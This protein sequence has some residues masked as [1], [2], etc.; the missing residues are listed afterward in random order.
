MPPGEKD[1]LRSLKIFLQTAVPLYTIRFKDLPWEDLKQIMRE[2]EKVLQESG[3]LAV[4][5]TIKKDATAK[6]FNAIAKAIAA[7]S[8]VPQGIDIFGLHFETKYEG[9][10][11]GKVLKRIAPPLA[12]PPA[13]ELTLEEFVG[14]PKMVD[15]SL[16]AWNEEAF[17]LHRAPYL[18]DYRIVSQF[19]C[20]EPRLTYFIDSPRLTF[21]CYSVAVL[22]KNPTYAILLSDMIDESTRE[23]LLEQ[24]LVGE[25]YPDAFGNVLGILEAHRG[26]GVG[27]E[28][29]AAAIEATGNVSPPPA[30]SPAGLKTRKKAH[31]IIVRNALLRGDQ[32]PEKVLDEYPDLQKTYRDYRLNHAMGAAADPGQEP[33]A[34]EFEHAVRRAFMGVYGPPS[35]PA[36]IQ[37]D[38][39]SSYLPE[40]RKLGWTEPHP[41][42]VLVI[43]ESGWVQDPYGPGTEHREWDRAMKVLHSLGWPQAWWDSI[44]PA[45]HVVMTGAV[46]GP[47]ERAL[48]ATTNGP[49]FWDKMADIYRRMGGERFL[50]WAERAV[51]PRDAWAHAVNMMAWNDRNSEFNLDPNIAES[52]ET[53]EGDE[54]TEADV[55][56]A[57]ESMAEGMV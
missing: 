6:A 28:F 57:M 50:K 19:F 5:T 27:P 12:G 38:I 52:R 55:A 10:S 51:A 17:L 33:A 31:K 14:H 45:V 34:E 9:P 1:A 13:H 3:E 15:E 25:F 40:G 39:R 22:K 35:D 44:N 23:T 56:L 18:H 30:F 46:R 53:R 2:S 49:K 29:L 4:F 41:Y 16:A 20:T 8:F 24:N 37:M 47:A 48:P 36:A 21:E 7:L 26:K 43:T 11:M 54:V 32:V 42:H